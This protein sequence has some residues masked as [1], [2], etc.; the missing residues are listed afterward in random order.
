M[1]RRLHLSA[2]LAGASLVLAPAVTRAQDAPPAEGDKPAET[3]APRPGETPPEEGPIEA[4]PAANQPTPAEPVPP[5][6]PPPAEAAPAPAPAPETKEAAPAAPATP[7]ASP[8]DQASA[9]AEAESASADELPEAG[10]VPG[11][12]RRPSLGLS[13]WTPPTIALAGGLTTPYGAPGPSDSWNFNFTGFFSAS[14]KAAIANRNTKVH[15]GQSDLVLKTPPVTADCYGCFTGTGSVLGSW[16]QM[17]FEYGN[18][19]TTARTSIN[20]YNPSRAISYTQISSQYFIGDAYLTFRVPQIDKLRIA[21]A[22]GAF[23][24][25]YGQL[26]RYSNLYGNPFLGGTGGTGEYLAAEYD[27]S[28]TLI[29]QA[30][31][32]FFGTYGKAPIGITENQSSGWADPQDPAPWTQVARLGVVRSG[33]TLIQGGLVFMYNWAQDDTAREPAGDDKARPAPPSIQDQTVWDDGNPKDPSFMSFGLESRVRGL[34]YHFG[35]AAGYV[36]ITDAW[37]LKGARFWVAGDGENMTNNWVGPESGG[38]GS[39]WGVGTELQVSWGSLVRLPEPFYDD[40]WNFVSTLAVQ[41]GAVNSK[42]NNPARDF[43]MYKIGLDNRYK[44]I[45]WLAVGLRA[46]R[47]VA[48]TSDNDKTFHVLAPRLEFQTNWTSHETITLQYAHW[49][50]GSEAAYINSNTQNLH[51]DTDVVSFGFGMWW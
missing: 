49:F 26:G 25:N 4:P 51:L 34:W 45:K 18:R 19:T 7:P 33:E 6:E 17:T 32:G 8:A 3:D 11:Y 31:H 35:L 47:V 24:I 16:V 29:L 13:P 44:P 20:T 10:Y 21:W 9:A 12:R 43:G 23:T 50:Y 38:N 1:K 36:K 30:E 14:L 28:D 5:T 37:N 22:V 27:L 40:G 48:D 15:E 2:V 42:A 41:G 39:M 46:D